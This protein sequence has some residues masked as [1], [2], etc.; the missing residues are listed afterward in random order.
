MGSAPWVSARLVWLLSRPRT[1]SLSRTDE[2]SGLVTT[3][4]SSAKYIAIWAPCSI[5]AGL[6]QTT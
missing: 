5:P 3:T 1:R 2:T 4:A 6:S